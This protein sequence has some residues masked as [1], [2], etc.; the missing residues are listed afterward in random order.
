MK[1]PL[2]WS[3]VS[4]SQPLASPW[5][6]AAKPRLSSTKELLWYDG[7]IHR[8]DEILDIA[9]VEGGDECPSQRGEDLARHSSASAS[10]RD[11][12]MQ[13]CAIATFS[14]TPAPTRLRGA[15]GTGKCDRGE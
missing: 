11:I 8:R 9:M 5:R 13:A 3:P 6:E 1:S 15:G 7:I 2:F 4:Q 12:S 10:R 14:Q